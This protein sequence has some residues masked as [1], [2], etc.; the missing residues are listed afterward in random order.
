MA[1]EE[2]QVEQVKVTELTESDK[3][4]LRNKTPASL[5]D[6]PSDKRWSA[7]Q[8][9]VKMYEG[10]LVLFEWIRRLAKE[11]NVIADKLQDGHDE[12]LSNVQNSMTAIQNQL[13]VLSQQSLVYDENGERIVEFYVSAEDHEFSLEEYAAEQAQ[14][15]EE[16]EEE[17]ES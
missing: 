16:Q 4:F 14:Q 13:D 1:D 12:D 15:S 3:A 11:V 5:P 17:E 7:S 10:Y 8:I 6:N 9:K 2:N